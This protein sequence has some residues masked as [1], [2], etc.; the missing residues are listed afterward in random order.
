M[1]NRETLNILHFQI[2]FIGGTFVLTTIDSNSD[3]YFE[4]IRI[5]ELV[6][7][8]NIISNKCLKIAPQ[9]LHNADILTVEKCAMVETKRNRLANKNI[10]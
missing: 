9:K 2:S 8:D 10:S 4:Q 7:I 5:S 6:Y 3:H 1:E